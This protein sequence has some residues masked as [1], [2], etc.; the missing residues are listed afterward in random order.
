MTDELD[1]LRALL[2]GATPAPWTIP[3][4]GSQHR[5]LSPMGNW[6]GDG[7]T[8]ED[9]RAIA[10]LGTVGLAMLAVVEAVEYTDERGAGMHPI[11]RDAID[12]FYAKLREHLGQP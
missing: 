2:E 3:E 1:Q 7:I 6:L 5:I 4:D 8:P 12:A 9:A 11:V 10:A